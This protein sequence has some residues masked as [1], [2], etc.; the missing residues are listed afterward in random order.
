MRTISLIPYQHGWF[1]LNIAAMAG[2]LVF[3]V[4]CALSLRLGEPDEGG[5]SEELE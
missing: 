4:R 2:M 5:E 3:F 1:W